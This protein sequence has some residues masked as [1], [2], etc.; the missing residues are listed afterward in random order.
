MKRFSKKILAAVFAIYFGCL[1]YLYVEQ[2]SLLYFPDKDV[3]GLQGSNLG[4]TKEVFITTVDNV[5]IQTWYHPPQPGKPMVLYYH[6]NS[7]NLEQRRAKFRELIDMGFGLI[8]PAWRGFGASEGSPTKEGIYNDARAAIAFLKSNG[9]NTSDTIVIGE[10]LGSG[11]AVQMATEEE[12]RGLLLITPYTSIS[13]RA[14]EIHWYMPVR[15]LIK[16]NFSSIDKI[17]AIKA[18]ILIVHGDQ[19]DVIPH[20]HAEK[21][22]RAINAKKEIIIYPGKAHN[23]LDNNEVFKEMKRFF[24]VSEIDEGR[25]AQDESSP[26]TSLAVR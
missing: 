24:Q 21:L 17:H 23:N 3:L 13:D 7:Y 20:K 2:R 8:V 16:D 6:G 15:A 4:D 11:V 1:G 18:P 5:K 19:D 10:S 26:E 25:F 22:Y 9:Y 14:Q 12:F